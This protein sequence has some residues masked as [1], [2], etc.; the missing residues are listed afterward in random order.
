MPTPHDL[1]LRGYWR[2]LR[3]R[4]GIVISMIVMMTLFGFIFSIINHPTP[5]YKAVASVKIEKTGPVTGAVSWPS[6]SHMETQREVIQSYF[7]LELVA[8]MLGRIPPALSSEAVLNTPRHRSIILDLKDRVE[9]QQEGNSDIINITATAEDPR[10]AQRLANT[11]AQVYQERHGLEL[12]KR[13]AQTRTFIENQAAVALEKLQKSEEALR[14][15]QEIHRMVS[16]EAQ[17]ASLIKQQANL[18]AAQ[19]RDQ[20]TLGKIDQIAKL[21]ARAVE[22]PL[23]SKTVLYFAEA[24]P[25]YK[26]LTERLAQLMLE[27][28]ILRINYTDLFPRIV[29]IQKQIHEIVVSLQSQLAAQKQILSRTVGLRQDRLAVLDDHLRDLPGKGM[30]LARLARDVSINKEIFTLLEKQ[31][32]ESL[33]RHA[34]KPQEVQIIKPALEPA[35]PANPPRTVAAAALGMLIGIILGVI[36]AFIS[37]TVATAGGERPADGDRPAA[38]DRKQPTTLGGRILALPERIRQQAKGFPGRR[39]PLKPARE[40]PPEKRR[41]PGSGGTRPVQALLLL[42]VL[43]LLIAALYYAW[44]LPYFAAAPSPP[45]EASPQAVRPPPS[46]LI[47]TP[48]A[49]KNNVADRVTDVSSLLK[50]PAVP[51]GKQKDAVLQT[52]TTPPV[53]PRAAAKPYVVQVRATQDARV[54]EDTVTA[55][56]TRGH[57][58]YSEKVVLEGK[59]AWLRVFIGRFPSEKAARQYIETSDI[60][61]VYPD[62]IVRRTDG[63]ATPKSPGSDQGPGKAPLPR[64]R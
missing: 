62:F 39:R 37:E 47:Q 38:G 54:A 5:L 12:N 32:Q 30:E 64:C 24:S 50:D 3:K 60:K 43:G 17:S 7:I 21:L 40:A 26:V 25:P 36:S 22:T 18:Q 51:A 19:D 2:T 14:D 45:G 29:E 11:I 20:A 44:S 27:R 49:R 16:L 28:D 41:P 13:N 9:T 35:N 55:L 4:R 59:G 23:S 34:E 1:N 52:V 63:L 15:F 57:D 10:E 56:K 33:L 53:P 46:P 6:T 58:A 48:A 42:L 61:T 8:K 31:H